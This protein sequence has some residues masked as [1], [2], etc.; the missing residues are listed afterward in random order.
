MTIIERVSRS[1]PVTK[2]S[3]DEF[4]RRH[5]LS[6]VRLAGALTGDRQAGELVVTGS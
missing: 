1:E 6:L 2:V 3:A 5:W 4:H